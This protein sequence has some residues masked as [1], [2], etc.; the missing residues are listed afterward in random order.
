MKNVKI[1]VISKANY[2]DLQEKYEIY[3]ENPCCVKENDVFIIKKLFRLKKG[4]EDGCF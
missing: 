1:T 4:V 2:A 3:Q